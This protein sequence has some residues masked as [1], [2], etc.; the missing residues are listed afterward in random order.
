MNKPLYITSTDALR[1]YG[2]YS[3]LSG[4]SNV[5][6]NRDWLIGTPNTN[7]KQLLIKNEKLEGIYLQSG[8][9]ATNTNLG[10]NKIITNSNGISLRRGGITVNDTQYTAGEIGATGTGTDTNLYI[11]G[12]GTNNVIID[13]SLG[14]IYCYNNAMNFY[15]GNGNRDLIAV[16]ETNV[17][18]IYKRSNIFY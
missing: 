11:N 2:N 15:R 5:T 8:S 10:Q 3:N 4:W 13:S 1:L 17:S 16:F 7:I 6:N 9:T 14:K 12:N 18:D